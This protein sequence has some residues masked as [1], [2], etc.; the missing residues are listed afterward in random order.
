[1]ET[2]WNETRDKARDQVRKSVCELD[3]GELYEME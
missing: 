1:M 2:N 3:K